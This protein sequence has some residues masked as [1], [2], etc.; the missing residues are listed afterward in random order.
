VRRGEEKRGC[1][2]GR[3]AGPL[4]PVCQM[5][6]LGVWTATHGRN[7]R[8]K[9]LESPGGPQPAV[10][11]SILP[12]LPPPRTKAMMMPHAS[13]AP[14]SSSRRASPLFRTS[15]TYRIAPE[16]HHLMLMRPEPPAPSHF[17]FWRHAAAT[18]GLTERAVGRGGA[19]VVRGL[20][21]AGREGPEPRPFQV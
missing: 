3:G 4:Y 12:S 5:V 15:P 13:P 18:H 9:Q 14:V 2:G 8:Q 16:P 20:A 21:Q 17:T 1:R 11:T 7:H 19:C 6:S 10:T